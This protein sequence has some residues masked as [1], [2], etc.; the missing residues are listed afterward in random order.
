M[1]NAEPYRGC[2]QRS[3]QN[4]DERKPR[5][6]GAQHHLL[7]EYKKKAVLRYAAAPLIE[8][9]QQE[10]M[11]SKIDRRSPSSSWRGAHFSTVD[12]SLGA[13]HAIVNT[14][15]IYL[16][17]DKPLGKMHS[18]WNRRVFAF[19]WDPAAITGLYLLFCDRRC[20]AE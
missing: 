6:S 1:K 12:E 10:E 19:F 14:R 15:Q 8:T 20:R 5:H 2:N 4:E 9:G 11:K 18:R 3:L 16:V 13:A 17:R 7:I